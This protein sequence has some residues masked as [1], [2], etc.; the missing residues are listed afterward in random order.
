MMLIIYNSS[1]SGVL[2]RS[3][4]RGTQAIVL[5]IDLTNDVSMDPLDDLYQQIATLSGFADETFPCIL[6]ANKCDDTENRIVPEHM[7]KDWT[8]GRRPGLGI[9]VIEVSAKTGA[10]VDK[11]FEAIIKLALEQPARMLSSGSN[12]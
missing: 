1:G 8:K 10:N 9:P 7:I 11:G 12:S 6:F 4:L 2:S 3:F 5:V